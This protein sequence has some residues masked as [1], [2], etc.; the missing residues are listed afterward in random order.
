MKQ[1][2]FSNSDK[3][4]RPYRN[5]LLALLIVLLVIA[6]VIATQFHTKRQEDVLSLLKA[7]DV[8]AQEPVQKPESPVKQMQDATKAAGES[9]TEDAGKDEPEDDATRFEKNKMMEIQKDILSSLRE[10]RDLQRALEKQLE[11]SSD[12]GKDIGDVNM[13]KLIKI[14]S[15]MR[16][17]EAAET[18][19]MMSDD[20]A[21]KILI[22]ISG[23]KASKIMGGLPP[24]HAAKL[25][26]KMV[27]MKPDLRLKN[28]MNNWQKIIEDAKKE[29]GKQV[30]QSQR[31]GGQKS[32][33]GD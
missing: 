15:S 27:E 21:V 18:L 28:V 22:S 17:E 29:E 32:Q 13:A 5:G 4:R 26:Q 20:L 19:P 7:P 8:N 6:T 10:V 11:V 1:V 30:E 25:G 12:R 2:Y 24:E 3:K 16:S 33:A 14:M 9:G 31:Y 23:N